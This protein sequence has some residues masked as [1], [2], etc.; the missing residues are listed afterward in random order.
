LFEGKGS[1]LSHLFGI[2]Q[3]LPHV[4]PDAVVDSLKDRKVEVFFGVDR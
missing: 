4:L 3:Y 1:S 2:G